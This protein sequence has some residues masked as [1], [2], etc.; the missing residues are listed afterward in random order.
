LSLINAAVGS[1]FY[2]DIL[3]ILGFVSLSRTNR[4]KKQP[5]TKIKRPHYPTRV[6][7]PQV[8]N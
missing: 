7:Y 4:E 8:G 5:I 2:R 3:P 1:V 6:I